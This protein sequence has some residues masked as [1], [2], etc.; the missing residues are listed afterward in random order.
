MLNIKVFRKE[1]VSILFLQTGV[2]ILSAKFIALKVY[3]C[4]MLLLP[5]CISSDSFTFFK[6]CFFRLR[7]V[8]LL[9]HPIEQQK[10]LRRY[11]RL[12]LPKPNLYSWFLN[13][14]LIFFSYLKGYFDILC[15]VTKNILIRRKI[16][17]K[18]LAR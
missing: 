7:L 17:L 14:I 6:N 10:M 3:S 16:N 2:K 4:A 13:L 18:K 9:L 1:L 11:S 12:R 15:K 8:G 5:I